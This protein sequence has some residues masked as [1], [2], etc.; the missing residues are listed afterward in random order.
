MNPADR[1]AAR[2]QPALLETSKAREPRR[3]KELELQA[4]WFAG[5]FGRDFQTTA[6]DAVRI[7]Q[8]GVWNR[9]AGPA[10]AEAA[11]SING[12]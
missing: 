5:D 12:G 3:M 8:F 7:V 10:F 6:G 2:L 4:H 9:E 11:I 1:Y